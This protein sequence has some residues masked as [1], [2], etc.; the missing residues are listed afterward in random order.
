MTRGLEGRRS[1]Q[2]SYGRRI[3]VGTAPV[4]PANRVS[5]AAQAGNRVR[6]GRTSVTAAARKI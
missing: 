1:V 4:G 6:I 2:L 5:G 3:R